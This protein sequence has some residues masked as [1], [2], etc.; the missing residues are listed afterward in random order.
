MYSPKINETLISPLYHQAK[1]L[2][3]QEVVYLLEHYSD[4]TT[5]R[6]CAVSDVF[7]SLNYP[8]LHTF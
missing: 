6:F 1:G 7:S 3:I 4:Q 5:E 2:K 8:F